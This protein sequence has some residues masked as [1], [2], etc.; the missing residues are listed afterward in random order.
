MLCKTDIAR[1]FTRALPS[2]AQN[3]PAQTQ[4]AGKL[5]TLLKQQFSGEAA[6]ALEIG[7]G[8]GIYSGLLQSSLPVQEWHVN[9]LST[10]CEAWVSAHR[11][12]GG[13]IETLALNTQYDLITSSSTFQWLADPAALVRKLN[14]CLNTGGILAFSTFTP[15]NL[16]QIKSLTGA[17]LDYPTEQEWRRL[18]LNCGFHVCHTESESLTLHFDS[19]LAV[20]QHLKYTGVTATQKQMWTKSRMQH[21]AEAYRNRYATDGRYPLTY[22]PLYIVAQKPLNTP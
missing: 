8:S 1:R 2:Y 15:E 16:F 5:L 21:F 13:D 10:A 18:L 7:C 22:T 11:F 6:C 12:L 9:D 17:G 3:A 19:P 4:I 20:L 14:A